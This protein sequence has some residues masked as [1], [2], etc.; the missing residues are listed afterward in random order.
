MTTPGSVPQADPS[1]PTNHLAPETDANHPFLGEWRWPGYV[2]AA[3]VSLYYMWVAWFGITDP[4]FDRSLF[5]F[6]GIAVSLCFYPLGRTYWARSVDVVLLAIALWA[7]VHFNLSYERYMMNA[8]FGLKP[9]DLALGAAITVISIEAAR[10]ALGL[11]I[12]IISVIFLAYMFFGDLA[13]GPL[14]HRGF[15]M[16]TVVSN[17]YAS[18]EGLYGVITYTL[19]SN[20]FLFL[21]FGQFLVRSGASDFFNDLSLAFLGHR[22]GGAAKAAVASSAVIGSVSGSAAANVAITGVIS[23]PLM[24][25]SGYSAHVAGATEAAASTGGTILPPIMGT[26]AFIMVALTGIP[27]SQIALYAAIPAVLYFLNVYLQIHFYARRRELRGLPKAECP[28]FRDVMKKSWPLLLPLLT[29]ITMVYLGFSLART[30]FFAIIASVICSW[31]NPATR[32]G[33][34]AIFW[35]LVD[36][37]KNSL[38]IIAVAGPVSVMTLA[39]LL[40][41]TG[42]KI[43]SMLI[44]FA[45][46]NLPATVAMIFVI[47]YVLGMGLSVVPAYII[48]ATLAA[49][50]LIRL[51]VPVMAAHFLVLWWGQ[52]SNITPP[53]ALASYVAA[54]ISGAPL[55]KTGNAAVIKGAGLFFLPVLFVFQPGLLFEGTALSIAMTLL[56]IIVG[57]VLVAGAIEGYLFRRLELVPRILYAVL[58]VLF[59]IAH[60][61]L[62]VGAL[63]ALT[64]LVHYGELRWVAR[65]PARAGKPIVHEGEA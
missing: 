37:T 62:V 30:A 46:G 60:D 53:V 26:A 54:N 15:G 5:I 3:C 29:V 63:A 51:D 19:A 31:W 65:N 44:D 59:I 27:Y 2:F 61:A 1:A 57:I 47:G 45:G 49:P 40:P 22:A 33:P 56:S 14:R 17:L 42:F 11:A 4:A 12:P 23:I 39:I 32:M 16:E 41:G 21:V 55:W 24:K 18:T 36:G 8:G 58:G 20:L 28:R 43:T 34:K 38:S 50:A 13:P 9:I 7:T 52:A 35:A 64:G 6:T 10:R 25:R 48:L